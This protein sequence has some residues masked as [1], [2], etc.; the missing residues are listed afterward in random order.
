MASI[1]PAPRRT[2]PF[3][4]PLDAFRA[5]LA[6]GVD[7]GAA[8]E[9]WLVVALGVHGLARLA[10]DAAERSAHAR[11][12][13]M[14][15][16]GLEAELPPALLAALGD[17]VLVDGGVAALRDLVGR[18]ELAGFLRLAHAML[19]VVPAAFPGLGARELG[20]LHMQR[21]RICRTLDFLDDAHDEYSRADAIGGAHGDA[22]LRARAAV[23]IGTLA[24]MRG[25]HPLA[26][27][28]YR[29][30]L[31]LAPAV[32]DLAVMAH[33]GLMADALEVG[34]D[35]RALVHGRLGFQVAGDHR[36]HRAGLLLNLGLVC[37]RR[38]EP[39]AAMRAYTNALALTDIPRTRVAALAGAATCAS[40]LGERDELARASA[41]LGA[42]PDDSAHAF[43]RAQALLI[44]AEAW[45]RSGDETTAQRC[46][47][48][49]EQLARRHGYHGIRFAAEREP[50]QVPGR[51]AEPARPAAL[52]LR[53]R[54]RGV[55]TW[56]R[57]LD[58]EDRCVTTPA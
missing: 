12:L 41:A 54:A 3:D 40:L 24:L 9:S 5:D 14:A 34:D 23:G 55:I 1:A 35:D 51:A 47:R 50:G 45:A 42:M 10:G 30:A 49:A 11:R 43:E 44:V 46:R 22:E 6:A 21:G 25:N 4:A 29:R 33:Q 17:P 39:A 52:P 36:V 28:L 57:S 38:G 7:A 56:L 19:A 26:R 20:M 8:R 15:W 18:L 37:E 32:T 16:S 53:R 31:R 13:R 48:R 58:V 2:A 27:R